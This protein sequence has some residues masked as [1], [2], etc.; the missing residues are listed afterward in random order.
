MTHKRVAIQTLGCRLNQY[1]TESIA[2]LLKKRGYVM[3]AFTANAD[4]YIINTCTVTSQ[5][6]RK[7]RNSIFRAL[8]TENEHA[9]V[10][11]TGCFTK[12]HAQE[13]YQKGVHYVVSNEKKAYI[14]DIID[15]HFRGEII[16]LDSYTPAKFQYTLPLP[17]FHTRTAIKIQDGC[18]NFCTFCIIPHVR[19]RAKSRSIARILTDIHQ[20]I[21]MGRKELIL[22][23]VNI[24]R[25]Q[26]EA[27]SFTQL[28][29]A[30]LEIK[31]DFRIRISSLEP[32][33]LNDQ[34]IKLME[35]PKLCPHLHLC[36]QSASNRILLKM[37][38][39][40][41][42]EQFAKII[43]RIRKQNPLFNFTTDVIVGFPGET[44]KD[45]MK[46]YT[47]AQQIGFSH[48]HVFPFSVRK[49]TRASRL[50]EQVSPQLIKERS[51]KLRAL[52]IDNTHRYRLQ[53]LNK[54][55]K[56]LI[57]KSGLHSFGLGEYY[58]PT[59]INASLEI[60]TFYD[61]TITAIDSHMDDPCLHAVCP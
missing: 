16:D 13:L 12:D 31:G 38:R 41:T 27:N 26:Y 17:L 5:A 43:E 23:G 22:T 3:V 34:F 24:S 20:A 46:T 6:D 37:R 53:F 9:I 52:S 58:L 49:G 42:V 40:Y 28:L 35:H 32:E 44:E 48:I 29:K 19:G 55:Q 15:A 8:R 59:R 33:H 50:P 57:E 14:P 54:K 7:S 10:I 18:D 39:T 56:V 47:F 45:F 61:A 60:N 36:L 30:I 25:Y 21:R 2:T 1:E 51:A 4:T 11:A